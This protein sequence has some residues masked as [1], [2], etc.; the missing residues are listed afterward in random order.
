MDSQEKRYFSIKDLKR[1]KQVILEIP[2]YDLFKTFLT[3]YDDF[4]FSEGCIQAIWNDEISGINEILFSWVQ[5][6]KNKEINK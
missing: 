4:L 1:N 3:T 2:T 5:I 6:D